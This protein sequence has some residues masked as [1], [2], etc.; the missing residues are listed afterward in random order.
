MALHGYQGDNIARQPPAAASVL[1]AVRA[2]EGACAKSR[3]STHFPQRQRV[4]A[5]YVHLWAGLAEQTGFW[6]GS[7]GPLKTLP[8][9]WESAGAVP[10][11]ETLQWEQLERPIPG[12]LC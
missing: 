9:Y 12:F 7:E 3:P 1:R 8:G 10:V 5:P 2:D 11:T 4:G 6:A